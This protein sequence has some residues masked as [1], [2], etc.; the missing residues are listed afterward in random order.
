MLLNGMPLQGASRFL[1]CTRNPR[2]GLALSRR[3]KFEVL[4]PLGLCEVARRLDGSA[5]GSGRHGIARPE[6][7]MYSIQM[8]AAYMYENRMVVIYIR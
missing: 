2:A 7:G 1:I 4:R 5:W 6:Q 8:T 3:A